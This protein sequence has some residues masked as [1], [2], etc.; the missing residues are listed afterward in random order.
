MSGVLSQLCTG[1]ILLLCDIFAS[2][3]NT[4]TGMHAICP[5]SFP[6]I[7]SIFLVANNSAR[8]PVYYCAFYL[9]GS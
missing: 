7:D 9:N 4:R 8:G 1:I 3:I 6:A 5:I 2:L